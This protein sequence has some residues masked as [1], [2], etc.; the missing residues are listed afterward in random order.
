MSFHFKFRD[1]VEG[2][3]I[4]YVS[5]VVEDG[6]FQRTFISRE[7]FTKW[8]FMTLEELLER[9]NPQEM[10]ENKSNRGD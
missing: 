7:K 9:R 4:P 5:E 1:V 3:A 2:T 6:R 10:E 8:W